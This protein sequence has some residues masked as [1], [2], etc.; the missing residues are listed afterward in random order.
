MILLNPGPVNVSPRVTAAL[1]RGD[2]CHREPEAYELLDR[3][4]DRLARAFAPRGGF[5]P[6]LITGSGT[7]ALEMA[8]TSAC[9]PAGRIVVVANGVYGERIAAMA[10]AARIAHTMVRSEW[11]AA[12]DLAALE[13]AVRAPD[14]ECVAVVHH[15]TTTGLLNPVA[16]V[17]A[18]ARRHGRLLLVDSVSGLGGDPLDLDATGADLVAGTANKCIQGVPG[19]AFVL[20]RTTVLERLA[21]HPPRSV[22]LSLAT[23][24][25]NAMPFTPAVQAAYAFDEALGELLE[26]GVDARHERYARAAAQLRTGFARLHLELVLPPRLRS[27]SITALRLPAGRTYREL[28]DGLKARGFVVYEGQGRLARELFRVANMGHLAS[29]DFDRFLAA[30]GEVLAS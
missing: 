29:A 15:E 11:I 5:T 8:V 24:A 19:M 12:P 2:L 21:A 30:L 10:S 28:H 25:T 16:A 22:Y 18:I 27:S 14:V 7:A 20:A 4:R 23:Y 9:S 17:G 6:V 13:D 1:A 26:E 3:I